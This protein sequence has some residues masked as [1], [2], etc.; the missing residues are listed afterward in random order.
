MCKLHKSKPTTVLVGW[1]ILLGKFG[2]G[3]KGRRILARSW[4]AP[5][6]FGQDRHSALSFWL[7]PKIF[8]NFLK[9]FENF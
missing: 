3:K 6:Q 2:A 4:P 5:G 7:V 9:I 1:R 8:K